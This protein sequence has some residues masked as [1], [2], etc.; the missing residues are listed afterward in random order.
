MTQKPIV[1]ENGAALRRPVRRGGWLALVMLC[2]LF[3]ALCLWYA[4]AHAPQEAPRPQTAHSFV[5]LIPDAQKPDSV[6]ITRGESAFT[7]LRRDGAFLLEGDE[8]ALDPHAAGELLACGD[9]TGDGN[10]NIKDFQRLLRH[11]NKTNPLF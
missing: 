10:V 7:L 6:T 3:L 8:T 2:A 4:A 1:L 11:I 5:Q 9:I